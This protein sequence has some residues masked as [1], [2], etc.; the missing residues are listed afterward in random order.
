MLPFKHEMSVIY[1]CTHESAFNI[2]LNNSESYSHYNDINFDHSL[3]VPS[4]PWFNA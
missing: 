3:P 1:T 2:S 4:R